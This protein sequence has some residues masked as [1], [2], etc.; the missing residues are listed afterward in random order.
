MP[1]PKTLALSCAL[2]VLPHLAGAQTGGMHEGFGALVRTVAPS[3][4]NITVEAESG[5]ARIPNSMLPQDGGP[6]EGA[7]SGFFI[8]ADGVIVT[9]NHVVEGAKRIRVETNTGAIFDATL[10]GTDPLTDLAVLDIEGTGYTPV[11]FGDSDAVEVGDWALAMGNPLGQGFSVSLGIVSARGRTLTGA[12]DDYIQTDAAINSGNSGG[13]LFDTDGRVIGV[14]TA[15]LSP[16]GGSIGIGFSMASNVAKDVVAQI[17]EHGETRRGWLG[18]QIQPITPDIA[19]ALDIEATTGA[20]I[21]GVVDGPAKTAGVQAGDIVTTINERA[22][23]SAQ[24]LTRATAAAG[25]GTTITLHVLR[26]GDTLTI[27]V[28]LGRREEAEAQARAHP[29]M[30]SA[31]P[32]TTTIAGVQVG[33]LEAPERE[34]LG[35]PSGVQG[36]VVLNVEGPVARALQGGDIIMGLNQSPTPN[37]EAF[38]DVASRILDSGRNLALAHILRD[39]KPLFLPIP[40][41]P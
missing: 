25:P 36:V 39:G 12:F 5:L 38:Q 32:K 20:L 28:E 26:N 37:P 2:A 31:T 9:N 27:P 3:V 33:T 7:G 34:A 41:V 22:I 19:S 35:L 40:M 18:V 1:T 23:Q 21:A 10:V 6:L 24:E 15:I 16:T 29:N 8:G 17:R 11:E 30:P 4:V 13:P 14:N